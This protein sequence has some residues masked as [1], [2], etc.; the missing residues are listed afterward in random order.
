MKKDW[1][2]NRV[3]TCL[4]K[5]VRVCVWQDVHENSNDQQKYVQINALQA[6]LGSSSN[7]K[8]GSTRRKY[9]K[10]KGMNSFLIVFCESMCWTE[11]VTD[12]RKKWAMNEENCFSHSKRKSHQQLVRPIPFRAWRRRKRRRRKK[13][14]RIQYEAVPETNQGHRKH[15]WEEKIGYKTGGVVEIIKE[16]RKNRR[17]AAHSWLQIEETSQKINLWL[18]DENWSRP[19]LWTG[20]KL[21]RHQEK[22]QSARFN[23]WSQLTGKKSIFCNRLSCGWCGHSK[24]MYIILRGRRW[25]IIII[26]R[27]E[28]S[29]VRA[30]KVSKRK[31]HLKN[32]FFGLKKRK[33]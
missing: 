13:C 27:L 2:Q 30:H 31:N 28:I 33:K 20:K 18:D 11:K 14:N 8:K 7:E 19:A 23:N 6:T 32:R 5:N 25:I 29:Q 10:K 26:M 21:R 9:M 15:W 3:Y 16:N 22:V 24:C 4:C 17:R 12:N 1:R